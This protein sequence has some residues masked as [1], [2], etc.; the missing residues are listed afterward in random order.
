MTNKKIWIIAVLDGISTGLYVALVAV[1]M[2]YA[3]NFFGEADS[4]LG[5]IAILMLMVLSVAVVGTLILG[6]PLMMYLDGAKKEAVKTL[7]F[8]ILVLFILTALALI[9]LAMK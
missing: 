5:G 4:A 1:F 8:T 9:I 2:T 3:N 6:R 7:G